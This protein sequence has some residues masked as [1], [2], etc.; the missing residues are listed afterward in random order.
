MGRKIL[1]VLLAAA[2]AAQA[3]Y[4]PAPYPQQNPYPQQAPYPQQGQYPQN[5]QQGPP[6]QYSQPGAAGPEVGADQQHGVARLSI[7]QGDIN[8]RRG[9]NGELV[10][11]IMNAPLMSQ[12]RLET[13][14][15]SRA[16][17]ELDYGDF[18]RL[19]PN[20]ELRFA[21]V[22]YHR[23]QLQLGA[24]T[25]VYRVLRSSDSQVE[26]DTPSSAIRPAGEGEFRIS[27]LGDGTTQITVRS[28]QAQ[29]FSPAGSQYVG[30]GRTMLVRGN[31]GNP[32]FQTGY[33]I[34][35]DQFD[36]WSANRDQ[37]LL[38]SQSYQYVS[39]DIEGADDLDQYGAWVPS[40]YG[41]VWAPQPPVPNW[42]P[43][44]YGEWVSEPYY[45]YT[46]V[47]YA[48]WGW[49]PYHY[50]RWFWNGGHGWCWWPGA[51]TASFL[52]SPALVG[53]FGW[54]GLGIGFGL[55]GLGWVALAPFELFHS[56]WG[57]GYGGWGR[58]GYYGGY[59][60]LDV[61]RMYRNAAFRGGAI[62]APYNGFGGPHHNFSFAARGQLTNAREFQGQL[63]VS[64]SRASFQYSNRQ[65]FANPQ[66]A[67]AGNRQFYQHQPS[68]TFGSSQPSS[69]GGHA[70][71]YA[72]AAP[73]TTRAPYAAAP[74]SGWQRFGEPR[75]PGGMSHSFVGGS[76]SSGWHSFGQPSP[77]V[78]S[79]GFGTR[80]GAAGG[81]V[82]NYSNSYS[83]GGR[84]NRGEPRYSAPAQQPRYSAPHYSAPQ[85]YS[86]PSSHGG[87]G[88]G[89][90][91]SEG[92]HSGGGHSGG[93]HS[94][95]GHSRH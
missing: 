17:V 92:G 22:E 50:G 95:G 12:D 56:W 59:H 74:S 91:H 48:P 86:A 4:A 83:A 41:Q 35:R 78:G 76:E 46:W 87:G 57:H 51:V 84:N 10:A 77:G 15:G 63:P 29:I 11:A 33:E 13:S 44:S 23:Y 1:T 85:H 19:A 88:G 71:G 7:V 32:E 24:G 20:T 81:R 90:S 66:L 36:D 93:G 31:P 58:P 65:A 62:T 43:Y 16:E 25:V 75:N 18:I 60:S 28:G 30:A 69:F 61:G 89:S 39:R 82:P 53:F 55:G 26:I 94:G 27:V 73:S 68:R 54:G 6:P 9:D 34:A 67:S 42:S 80:S 40:Q 52:W 3:Q 38:R 70:N 14:A 64:S 37:E 2:I 79:M 47:D 5:P 21:D 49:A 45:G 8:V 72:A